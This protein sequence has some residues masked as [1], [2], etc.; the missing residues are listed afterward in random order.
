[1]AVFNATDAKL[2]KAGTPDQ[3]ITKTRT[4]SFNMTA[5]TIDVTTKDSNGWREILLGLR[6]ASGSVEGLIDYAEGGTDLNVD[7]LTAAF[8]AR[9]KLSLKFKLASATVG[10][11]IISF[12]CFLTSLPR[13][14]NMEE[15]ASFSV[16][17][18]VT[19]VPTFTT[20]TV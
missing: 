7:Q 13:T 4:A 5:A 10:S 16:D 11:E 19:G 3:L 9:E 18:E 8:M 2:Y 12:D 1:M 14:F 6:Q 15:A 17:F 20:V